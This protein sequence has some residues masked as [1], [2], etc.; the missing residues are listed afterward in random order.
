MRFQKPVKNW[1]DYIRVDNHPTN[2]STAI[3]TPINIKRSSIFSK[4][5]LRKITS[6][7]FSMMLM[8]SFISPVIV[9]AAESG[10]FKEIVTCKGD[11]KWEDLIALGQ[12]IIDDAVVLVGIVSVI[13]ITYAGYL[14]ATAGGNDSQISKAHAV[15][16]KVMWG[17]FLTLGAWLLV[18]QMLK[19]LDVKDGFSILQ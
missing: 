3:H 1:I 17:I 6:I 8:C 13:S 18:Y 10:V 4:K 12:N 19:W 11:C 9:S 7:F 16:E 14:Y 15:F 2:M 5:I